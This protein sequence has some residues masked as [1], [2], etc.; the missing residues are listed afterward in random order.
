MHQYVSPI[1]RNEDGSEYIHLIAEVS[2]SGSLVVD[3]SDYPDAW[4]LLFIFNK[5]PNPWEA[6][7]GYIDGVV[8]TVLKYYQLDGI[9]P[10]ALT[11]GDCYEV[12]IEH[13]EKLDFEVMIF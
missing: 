3:I 4:V 12:I 2:N 13:K 6:M 9:I 8:N 11:P 5:Y 1:M 7:R 10:T